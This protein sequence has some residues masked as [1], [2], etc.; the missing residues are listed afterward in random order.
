[1][2][3]SNVNYKFAREVLPSAIHSNPDIFYD[4]YILPGYDTLEKTLFSAWLS[5]SKSMTENVELVRCSNFSISIS[6]IYED[7]SVLLVITLPPSTEGVFAVSLLISETFDDE[8]S[9]MHIDYSILSKSYY[10]NKY[11]LM[12]VDRDNNMMFNGYIAKGK[13]SMLRKLLE[14]SKKQ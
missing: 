1:M 2:S 6:H 12:S 13:F 3:I 11:I 14:N 8:F 7:G 9:C 5:L 4:N 10:E